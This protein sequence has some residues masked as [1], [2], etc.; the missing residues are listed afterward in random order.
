MAIKEYQYTLIIPTRNR[1]HNAIHAIQSAISCDYQKLQIVVTDNSDDDSLK[2]L[3]A[4]RGWTKYVKYYKTEKTLAMH[5]N[6]SKGLDLSEGEYVSI[7]G[8]DDAIFPD[9]PL[10][11]NALLSQKRCQVI[12]T[13]C[14]E[15]K[16]PDYPF[17]G[18]RN[19]LSVPMG[20]KVA[21]VN[22]VHRLLRDAISHKVDIGTGPGIYRGFVERNFL[23]MLKNKRGAWFVEHQPDLD[24]GYCTLMYAEGFLINSRPMFMDGHCGKSNSGAMRSSPMMTNSIINS[25]KEVGP[26][27][28]IF[29][30]N[31]PKTVRSSIIAGQERMLPE[32]RKALNDDTLVIDMKRAWEHMSKGT[33]QGYDSNAVLRDAENLQK[34]AHL[35]KIDKQVQH[36][37]QITLALSTHEDQGLINIG[38]DV[39]GSE[40]V[41]YVR[42]DGNAVEIN[43]INQAL[44]LANA[45]IA[46]VH[47]LVE[48]R[49]S[50]LYNYLVRHRFRHHG[51]MMQQAQFAVNN[52]Q[53]THAEELVLRVC[54]ENSLDADAY[55]S[56]GN[57]RIQLSN[58]TGAAAVYARAMSI[59]PTFTVAERFAWVLCQLGQIEN[60]RELIEQIRAEAIKENLQS[61][62][63]AMES[64]VA[65]AQQAH[66]AAADSK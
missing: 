58:F 54:S 19:Y 20:H 46:P 8:D 30:S 16:W 11:C 51:A 5:E 37:A 53:L 12:S 45:M 22:A 21:Y 65:N 9:A 15:Y 26:D 66:A 55:A 3:I 13:Q 62:V 64:H 32:I 29:P 48:S 25:T 61:L 24:S 47:K 39:E 14:A 27:H 18:R 40:K 17:P 31:W 34:L 10:V 7:I 4:E 36:Q 56:L 59:K 42:I 49:N 1:Q 35:W 50:D 6:W 52:H 43:D 23:E 57:I 2:R 28:E 38:Q 44:A 63:M 41:T 33:Q 60:A